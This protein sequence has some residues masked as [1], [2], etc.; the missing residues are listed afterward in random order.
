MT[1][2]Y[3]TL[4]YWC[5]VMMSSLTVIFYTEISPTFWAIKLCL[6]QSYDK[7]NPILKNVSYKIYEMSQSCSLK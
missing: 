5:N 3:I 6:K 2:G 7:Q 1:K 4:G